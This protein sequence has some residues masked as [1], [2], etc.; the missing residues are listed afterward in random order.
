MKRYL[1][2]LLSTAA[3]AAMTVAMFSCKDDPDPVIPVVSF[4][5]ATRTVGE[6]AGT[7]DVL[8]QL[9]VE[10]PR[11]ITVRYAVSGTA[12]EGTTSSSDYQVLGTYGETV[13][14]KG[15][16]G[17]KI[18]LQIKQDAAV[19]ADETIILTISEIVN[20]YATIGAT[21]ATTITLQS[22]DAGSKV[23]FATATETVNETVGLVNVQVTLDKAAAQ[24]ITVEYA[25][26]YDN[27]STVA[28]ALD[29]VYAHS[30]GY[31]SRY[32]D[33]VVEGGNY[34]KVVIPAGSTTGTITLRIYSD[35]M[36]EDDETIEINLKSATLGGQLG[37][38]TKHTIT[39][40]QE[41]GRVIAL[42]WDPSY[43]D[44]DMDLFLWI[45][46]DATNL[47]PLA[48]SADPGTTVKSEVIIIPKVLSDAI[49][50][51][52]CGLSFVYYAGTPNPMNFKVHHLNYTNGQLE[53][54]ANWQ[55]FSGA[56]T[57]A[58][59]NK[60]DL[61][62]GTEPQ[63]EQSFEL[64]AKAYTNLSTPLNIPATG[65]RRATLQL[66]ANIYKSK[67]TPPFSNRVFK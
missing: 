12:T 46:D 16:T 10:A 3:I 43:T 55:T 18:Q 35:F 11:D 30:E 15:T 53:D 13:I 56:Y 45:G 34:G 65:S 57:P 32:Y 50:N 38:A 4:Q 2:R 54:E 61:A 37:T 33:F 5:Q 59:I 67:S 25:F 22:D 60:W 6:D 49:E 36:F 21:P 28:T 42:V 24:D 40:T 58:N 26:N 64:V 44:V 62:A 19:E 1:T 48:I 47:R 66:P 14:T 20:A 41:D 7:I 63:I 9:D 51:A 29:T 52:A 8:L 17:G 27:I 31:P 23:S 39:V